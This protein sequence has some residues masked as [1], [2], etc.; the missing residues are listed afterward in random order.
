MEGD[1]MLELLA[2]ILVTLLAGRRY[3]TRRLNKI[4]KALEQVNSE[5]DSRI[6]TLSACATVL[7]RDVEGLSA[8]IDDIEVK[9]NTPPPLPPE[10]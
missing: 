10:D 1:P 5:N 6:D 9:I 3:T 4:N 8:R 7:T 2:F